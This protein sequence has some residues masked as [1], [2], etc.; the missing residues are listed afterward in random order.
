[1]DPS[2]ERLQTPEECDQFVENVASKYPELARQARQRA[3][4]LRAA[5]HGATT[6]AERDGLEALYA[7]EGALFVKHGKR[8]PATYIRRK[9]AKDGIMAAIEHAVTQHCEPVGYTTLKELGL[10]HQTFEAVVLKHPA[11]FSA[12]AVER[13]KERLK[14][15]NA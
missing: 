2:V 15:W 9:V 11:A 3:I 7:S 10:E 8:R 14:D 13:S 4:A 12:E 5:A 1:M 6:A